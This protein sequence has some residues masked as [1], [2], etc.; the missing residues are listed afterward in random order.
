M[1]SRER[2]LNCYC[3]KKRWARAAD[4]AALSVQ[5]SSGGKWTGIGNCCRARRRPLLAETPPPIRMERALI[6]L[7]ARLSLVVMTSM[8]A[9]W[10]LAAMF[11]IWFSV[12]GVVGCAHTTPFLG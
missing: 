6:F 3:S 9:D 1:A 2:G 8:Q 7:A 10:K 12:G 11:A 5:Y 4:M